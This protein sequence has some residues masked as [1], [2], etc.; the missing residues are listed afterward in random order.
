MDN[1]CVYNYVRVGDDRIAYIGSF[2]E[3]V[4][5]YRKYVEK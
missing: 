4:Y 3:T 2:G 5:R 1:I